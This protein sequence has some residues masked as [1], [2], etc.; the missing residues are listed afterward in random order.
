MTTDPLHPFRH[1]KVPSVITVCS[2]G[3]QADEI[4]LPM[5]TLAPPDNNY[6]QHSTVTGMRGKLMIQ[7]RVIVQG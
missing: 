7:G 6:S 3:L 1:Q 5:L 2:D 4:P